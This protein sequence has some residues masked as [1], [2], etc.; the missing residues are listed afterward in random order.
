VFVDGSANAVRVATSGPVNHPDVTYG[1]EVAGL[2]YGALRHQ[3]THF[4]DCI[5]FGGE[6]LVSPAEA[7]QAVAGI[8]A[9]ERSLKTGAP[10]YLGRKPK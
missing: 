6:P 9:M 10:V 2:S 5:R 7:A 4:V 3:L 8:C 1:P